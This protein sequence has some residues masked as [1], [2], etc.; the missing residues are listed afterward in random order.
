[1]NN[2]YINMNKLRQSTREY[3]E[4]KDTALDHLINKRKY[5]KVAINDITV[6]ELHTKKGAKFDRKLMNNDR[7]MMKSSLQEDINYFDEL[8]APS[9]GAYYAHAMRVTSYKQKV[10][11]YNEALRPFNEHA[12]RVREE[13]A[14]KMDAKYSNSSASRRFLYSIGKKTAKIT[15]PYPMHDKIE[16][17]KAIRST[18]SRSNY[19][20]YKFINKSKSKA[21]KF[22][23]RN[24]LEQGK[25]LAKNMESVRAYYL[26][27][28]PWCESTLRMQMS[29]FKEQAMRD[30]SVKD[31]SQAEIMRSTRRLEDS[32]NVLALEGYL[33]KVDG[34]SIAVEL[35]FDNFT[36][37]PSDL[38]DV[39]NDK[40][41]QKI[42]DFETG[43]VSITDGMIEASYTITDIADNTH[44]DVVYSTD[45]YTTS[46]VSDLCAIYGYDSPDDVFDDMDFS[47]EVTASTDTE[48]PEPIIK[49][50][51]IDTIEVDSD[52]FEIEY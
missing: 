32:I 21:Q 37:I 6:N 38:E 15:I 44:T 18:M 46:G 17:H 24:E 3:H 4:S 43:N 28:E 26:S 23:N 11:S 48:V 1:M 45:E 42:N 22:A 34:Y 36:Y 39:I 27:R 9:M 50:D 8:M 29:I 16:Q 49:P 51:D 41:D 10:N 20:Q 47:P 19:K 2:Q 12:I 52:G 40:I 5:E 7:R 25:I 31:I 14:L 30:L 13:Y 35:G 33:D